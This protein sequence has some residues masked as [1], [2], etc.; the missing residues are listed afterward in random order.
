MTRDQKLDLMFSKDLLTTMLS[1]SCLKLVPENLIKTEESR[2]QTKRAELR[3][4][5]VYQNSD[6]YVI[7][8]AI[9]VHHL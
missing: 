4:E 9:V 3:I 1:V 5:Y 7:S 2:L 6:E 8:T